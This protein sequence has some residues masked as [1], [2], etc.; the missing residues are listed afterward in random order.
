[1]CILSLSQ[2]SLILS[3]SFEKLFRKL[4]EPFKV[5]AFGANFV[6][7]VALGCAIICFDG[8]PDTA[9]VCSAAVTVVIAEVQFGFFWNLERVVAVDEWSRLI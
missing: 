6:G 1:M 9:S 2:E 8:T 3:R 5:N 7:F 4:T